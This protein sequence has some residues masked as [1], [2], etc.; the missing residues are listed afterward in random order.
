M[1]TRKASKRQAR[2]ASAPSIKSATWFPAP[3]HAGFISGDHVLLNYT[4]RNGIQSVVNLQG[5]LRLSWMGVLKRLPTVRHPANRSWTLYLIGLAITPSGTCIADGFELPAKDRVDQAQLASSARDW[6]LTPGTVQH[7]VSP[8][9]ILSGLGWY[10]EPPESNRQYTEALKYIESLE[11]ETERKSARTELERKKAVLTKL[12]AT[13]SRAAEAEA[14]RRRTPPKNDERDGWLTEQ[15]QDGYTY[16]TVLNMLAVEIESGRPWNVVETVPGV[17]NAIISY[18]R[19]HGV[20][21]R[22]SK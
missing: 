9:E 2:K 1:G 4:A 18:A 17:R 10:F 5:G 14:E 13:L 19:R 12:L 16:A 11:D 21:L 20:V 15:Y 7:E 3:T 22:R 8:A 6:R